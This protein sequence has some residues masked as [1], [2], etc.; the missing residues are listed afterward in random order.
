M[1][2]IHNRLLPLFCSHNCIVYMLNFRQASPGT[3]SSR[4]SFKTPELNI[5]H[6]FKEDVRPPG[7][8]AEKA[9]KVRSKNTF[10]ALGRKRPFWV[11]FSSEFPPLLR[12]PF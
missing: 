10:M 4:G 7:K 11:A 6:S 8:K 9:E 3:Y 5:Q 12:R 2:N 1:N